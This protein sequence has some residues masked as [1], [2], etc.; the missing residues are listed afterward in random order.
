MKQDY[1]VI[2]LFCIVMIICFLACIGYSEYKKRKKRKKPKIT[3]LQVVE[4]EVEVDER[5]FLIAIYSNGEKVIMNKDKPLNLENME[6]Y[7]EKEM[8]K[9][10]TK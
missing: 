10:C 8:E 1:I 7:F 5:F 6:K 4:Q 3:Q 9:L 2:A